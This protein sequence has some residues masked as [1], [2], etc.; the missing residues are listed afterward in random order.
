MTSKLAVQMFTV[1]EHTK[2][3]RDLA[4]TLRKI[5]EIGYEAVQISAVGAM[6]GDHPEVDASLARRMLDDNGLRC[7]ATHRPWERI[8]SETEA[9]IAFHQTLGCDYMAIGGILGLYE[10]SYEGY[11]AFAKVAETIIE[12]LKTSGIRFGH[13]NHSLEFFRPERHGKTLEDILIDEASPELMLELDLYWIEHAGLNCVRILER[14]HGRVPVIHLKDKEVIEGTN[15]PRM[16]PIGEGNMDWSTIIPA[17][18]AAGVNWYAVEQDDC[19]RDPF[20]CLKSSYDFLTGMDS[21][22]DCQ[23][24]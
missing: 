12:R 24:L 19:Y 2:T 20:D 16:A 4:E 7:I 10:Q 15:E 3:V 18:E 8:L 21:I 9:E 17:C 5:R 14:C 6:N 11:R 23:A 1:R 13:H 22:R